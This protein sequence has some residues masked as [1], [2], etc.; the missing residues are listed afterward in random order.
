[1]RLNHIHLQVRDLPSALAWLDRVWEAS[2]TFRN[3]RMALVPFGSFLLILDVSDQDSAA[4]IGFE[5]DDCNGDYQRVLARGAVSI[6]EP[7]DRPW[8]ARAAYIQGPGALK[9]EIEQPLITA[10]EK[11]ASG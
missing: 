7:R 11:R 6:D 2:A 3:E 5:S 4:T 9:F 8:G 1:M 10:S